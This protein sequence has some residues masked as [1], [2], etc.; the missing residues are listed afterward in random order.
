MNNYLKTG[1]NTAVAGLGTILL[2]SGGA[3]VQA[4]DTWTGLVVGVVGL[5]AYVI[6]E[7]IP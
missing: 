3:L 1:I 2:A 6:Y 4:G 5:I 7:V